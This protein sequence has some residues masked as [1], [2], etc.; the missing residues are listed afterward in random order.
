MLDFWF[1]LGSA[2]MD[3]NLLT[4]VENAKPS[5]LQVNREIRENGAIVIANNPASGLLGDNAANPATTRVR[6]AIRGYLKKNSASPPISIYAAGKLSQLVQVPQIKF[7]DNIKLANN[8]Y[9]QA[10]GMANVANDPKSFSPQFPAFLG[11][12]LVDASLSVLFSSGGADL[13]EVI[14]EFGVNPD[15]AQPDLKVMNQTL[16]FKSAGATTPDFVTAQNDLLNGLAWQG[17]CREQIIFWTGLNGGDGNER[18]VL[19]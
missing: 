5:F 3:P 13:D 16:T 18:A 2:V 8:A 14:E 9:V 6:L 1:T 17:G 12:C 4:V 15:P 11:L 7:R 10:C 19:P